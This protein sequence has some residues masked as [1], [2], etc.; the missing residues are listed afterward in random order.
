MTGYGSTDVVFILLGK[1]RL[2]ISEAQRILKVFGVVKNNIPPPSSKLTPFTMDTQKF[3][4][5]FKEVLAR[6]LDNMP[7]IFTNTNLD[8]RIQIELRKRQRLSAA[9]TI[10][11]LSHSPSS[12]S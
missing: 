12:Y 1:L 5:L 7:S 2:S 6:E 8:K 11:C 3:L 10:P 9:T 4:G